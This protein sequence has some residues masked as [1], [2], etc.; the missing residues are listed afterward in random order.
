MHL[1]GSM[2]RETLFVLLKIKNLPCPGDGSFQD[3]EKA[4]DVTHPKDLGHFLS[5][6]AVFM[7]AV[8]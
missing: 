7:P 4:I 5:G 3:F 6:F 2:R 8:Q 1:D